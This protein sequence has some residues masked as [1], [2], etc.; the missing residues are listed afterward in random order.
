MT[1]L[2]EMVIRV[3]AVLAKHEIGL[4]L[5]A[6]NLIDIFRLK[7]EGA[8]GGRCCFFFNS[9]ATTI[10]KY[11]FVIVGTPDVV[12]V[13]LQAFGLLNSFGFLFF[14]TQCLLLSSLLLGFSL[15]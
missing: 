1:P 6:N 14:I 7:A 5:F 4:A 3:E 9:T 2:A 13:E 12:K 8:R 15:L 11:T 10:F